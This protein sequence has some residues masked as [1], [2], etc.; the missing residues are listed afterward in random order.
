MCAF[1]NKSAFSDPPLSRKGR[2]HR[3]PEPL[4]PKSRSSNLS[5]NV[6]LNPASIISKLQ[7]T[8]SV[9]GVSFQ[10]HDTSEPSPTSPLQVCSLFFFAIPSHLTCVVDRYKLKSIVWMES[11]CR[12]CTL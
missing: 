6:K 4:V 7:P 10:V 12:F 8:V 5:P 2:M 1:L 11:P 3:E 9:S